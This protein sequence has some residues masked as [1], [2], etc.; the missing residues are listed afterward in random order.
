MDYAIRLEMLLKKANS[1]L[2]L[3]KSVNANMIKPKHYK[4]LNQ[5]GTWRDSLID[6]CHQLLF[7][8]AGRC[9]IDH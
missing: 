4:F 3:L 8:I 5:F 9:N 6:R 2:N 1:N 7:I